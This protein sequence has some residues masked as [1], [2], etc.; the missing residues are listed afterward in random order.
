MKLHKYKVVVEHDKGVT[1]FIVWAT[2]MVQAREQVK[3]A[4]GCPD[5]AILL[6]LKAR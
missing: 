3:A 5:R 4:E 1:T 2:S 6:T